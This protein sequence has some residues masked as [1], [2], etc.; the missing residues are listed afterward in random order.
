M[1]KIS[2]KIKLLEKITGKKVVLFE[3]TLYVDYIG[4]QYEAWF[5]DAGDRHKALS[6][7]DYNDI[8]KWKRK[9]DFDKIVLTDECKA[10]LRS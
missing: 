8:L 4:G 10:H 2:N 3:A 6:S 7:H 5:N 1:N 9:N